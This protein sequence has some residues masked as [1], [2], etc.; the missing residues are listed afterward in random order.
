MLDIRYAKSAGA[1]I[2]YHVVGEGDP[3]LVYVPDYVSNLVYDWTSP[4][5]RGFYERMAQ[6][7]RVIR[8]DKRGTGLSDGGPQFATLETRMEDLGAVLDAVG[9][10]R[11]VVL[12][13][14]EGCAMA[15]LYAATYP[16]R[17]IALALF[18]PI[19]RGPLHDDEAQRADLRRL[20]DEWGTQEWC[21]EL[22][23]QGA[24][25]MAD[26]DEAREWFANRLRVGAS[27]AVA[28]AL[29]VAFYETDLVDVLPAV[30]VPTLV[31]YRG[32]AEEDALDVA[33][34][35]PSAHAVRVPGDDYLAIFLSPEIVDEIETF[36]AGEP[37]P[38]VPDTVLATVMFTDI[39]GSTE[40]AAELGDR[41]WRDLLAKHHMLVR[42][43]LARYRG[44][45]RDTAGDGFFAT[46][47][48]PARA[49]RCAQA[50]IEGVR[51]LDLEV[52]A[53]V[54]AGECEVHD[55]KVAGI[56]VAVG[57]RVAAAAA[58][59]EV[60]VSSTVKDLVAGS[61]LEFEDRG[62]HELKGVP[63]EWRLYAVRDS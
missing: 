4:Y 16:E 7:F 2:A 38:V 6:S 24:P 63:G 59:G 8:F 56:A 30:R 48:G 1:S 15:T 54:H 9:S 23:R 37:T 53:G 14:H 27:P 29:N 20:R 42:R 58:A 28:Y 40:R 32:V 11:A 5:W 33:R 45:E 35:I 19:A 22:L 17:V 55:E 49:I 31:L 10:K 60:L 44:E 25:S 3:D 52:R 50:I 18:H 57:A 21:D 62:T 43:E 41:A 34:R 12:A 26:R 61:G 46:F 51:E 36:V 13:G 39:V 47:D